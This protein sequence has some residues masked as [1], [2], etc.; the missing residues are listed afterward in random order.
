MLFATEA[1]VFPADHALAEE[2]F[3]AASLVMRCREAGEVRAVPEML[4]SQLTVALHEDADD[5]EAASGLLPLLER[6]VRRILVNGFGSGVEVRH[7]MVHGDPYPATSDGRTTSVGSL[8]IARFLRPVCYQDMPDT[9][10]PKALR[11][12]NLTCFRIAKT[13]CASCPS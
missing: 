7:A 8:A 12:G 3:R 4:W 10:L 2:V 9:L 1:R 13:P 6:N 5:H 11:A